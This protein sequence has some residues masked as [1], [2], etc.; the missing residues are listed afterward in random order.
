MQGIYRNQT[1][2]YIYICQAQV[3]VHDYNPLAQQGKG[4][5]QIDN[6]TCFPD[7]AFAAGN[8]N[9]PQYSLPAEDFSLLRN[10]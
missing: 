3:G 5:G 8:G 9:Y 1:Y 10:G 6:D 2:Y 4:N 7:P